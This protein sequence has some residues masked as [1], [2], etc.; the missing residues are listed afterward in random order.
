LQIEVVGKTS[1]AIRFHGNISFAVCRW[2]QWQPLMRYCIERDC[3]FP[4]SDPRITEMLKE[5]AGG[6]CRK[7]NGDRFF[8]EAV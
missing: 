8:R 7:W 3:Q 1:L 5:G 2:P 4:R 6:V